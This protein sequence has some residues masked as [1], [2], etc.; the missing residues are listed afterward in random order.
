MARVSH[1]IPTHLNVEDKLVLGLAARPALHLMAG[2]SQAYALWSGGPDVPDPIR[3]AMVAACLV[4][5]ALCAFLHPYGRPLDAWAF[6]ALRYAALAKVAT[7]RPAEANRCAQT[8][9]ADWA[10]L[11]PTLAWAG[12]ERGS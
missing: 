12:G 2:L 1:Q 9:S 11:A 7:W 5:S 4:V 3:L 8:E 6:V 10:D